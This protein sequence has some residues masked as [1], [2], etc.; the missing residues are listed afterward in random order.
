L[1]RAAEAKGLTAKIFE[2]SDYVLA[3]LK[4]TGNVNP[5]HTR[6]SLAKTPNGINGILVRGRERRKED[7]YYW[8]RQL[9]SDLWT[10]KP[11]VAIIPNIRFEKE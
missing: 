10:Q 5:W 7:P 4:N 3:D 1:V 2:I 6:E 9:N 8:L 11:D